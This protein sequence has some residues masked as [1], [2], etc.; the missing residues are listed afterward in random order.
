MTDG[1]TSVITQLE[2]QKAAIEAAL[3]ALRG[4]EG[5][6]AA[7]EERSTP[8]VRK[9]GMTPEGKKRLIKA[10]KKRW[11]AKRAAA[12]S[13]AA[14]ELVVPTNKRF[15]AQGGRWAAKKAKTPTATRK[16]GMT[17]DGRKRLAEAMK[18][19][20]AVKRAAAKKQAG[21]RKLAGKK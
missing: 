17:D 6:T 8:A 9:G 7:T 21:A 18:R 5:E 10:L 3:G 20:W 13:A 15:G 16:G 1:I 19:R 12:E 14:S 11:A 4:L 2:A